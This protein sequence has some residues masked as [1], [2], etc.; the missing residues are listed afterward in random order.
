M[1]VSVAHGVLKKRELIFE[2]AIIEGVGELSA[3]GQNKNAQ[4]SR[5]I[6]EK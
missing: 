3:G 6:T 4:S 5:N 2:H 1:C